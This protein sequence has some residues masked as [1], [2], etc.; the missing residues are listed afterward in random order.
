MESL[1]R[2][3][4]GARWGFTPEDLAQTVQRATELMDS[5]D[6]RA[7]VRMA[8]VLLRMQATNE[9]GSRF[10]W[11]EPWPIPPETL[12]RAREIVQGDRDRRKARR[13]RRRI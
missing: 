3:T 6:P 1:H 2:Q 13:D 5:N 11:F 8:R 9:R 10:P 7:A 12:A 4:W